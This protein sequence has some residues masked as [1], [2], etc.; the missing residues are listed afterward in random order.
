MRTK[1]FL[2]VMAMFFAIGLSF[3]SVEKAIDPSTDYILQNGTFEP[4][5]ME[6]DC[7]PKQSTCQVQLEPNGQIYD[8]YD[9]PDPKTLKEG[10]GEVFRIWK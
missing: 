2:P 5:G 9:A 1:F 6:L 3:A 10:S 7:D 8:V 4:I